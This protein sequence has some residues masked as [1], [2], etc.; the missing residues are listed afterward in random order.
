M[1]GQFLAQVT[2]NGDVIIA[3]EIQALCCHFLQLSHVD[4]VGIE[5]TCSHAG[6]LASDLAIVAYGNGI[7]RSFPGRTSRIPL[8]IDRLFFLIS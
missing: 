7:I 3:L 5:R 2:V 4:S 1:D 6:N 8:N